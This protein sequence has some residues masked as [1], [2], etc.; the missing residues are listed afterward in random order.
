[1]LGDLDHIVVLLEHM[2]YTLFYEE[3]LIENIVGNE[4]G[5]MGMENP[6]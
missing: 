6:S 3:T 4:L 1:M 5:L 2:R